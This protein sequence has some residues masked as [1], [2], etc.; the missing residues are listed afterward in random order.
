MSKSYQGRILYT[1][2]LLV[3]SDRSG[4]DASVKKSLDQMWAAASGRALINDIVAAPKKVKIVPY[5]STD[6]N[7]ATIPRSITH[8]TYKHRPVR[9]GT[10]VHNPSW[11]RGTGRGT[12]VRVE[13]TPWRYHVNLQAAGLVHEMTHAAQLL[14]GVVFT[15]PMKW[16]FDTVAEFDAIL[17]EN[18]FRCEIGQSI[19]R[20]HHGDTPMQGDRMIP[21]GGELEA[22]LDSF[23]ARMPGLADSLAQIDIPFNPLRQGA[24]G[25]Y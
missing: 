22:R 24:R 5:Y 2:D 20:N 13:F 9:G 16:H 21:H 12:D 11:A 7:A 15:N 6:I 4:W 19:R 8:G 17:V 3:G 18:I 1:A 10:G 14:R 23:K 25:S